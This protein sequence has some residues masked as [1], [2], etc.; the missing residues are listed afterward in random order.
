ML[1]FSHFSL[2]NLASL[3][4]ITVALAEVWRST[5]VG[6]ARRRMLAFLSGCALYVGAVVLDTGTYSL[7]SLPFFEFEYPAIFFEI[8][9]FVELS[10]HVAGVDNKRHVLATRVFAAIVVPI[11]LYF[12]YIAVSSNAAYDSAAYHLLLPLPV[13]LSSYTFLLL[14]AVLFKKT[15]VLPVFLLSL[16]KA[17]PADDFRSKATYYLFLAAGLFV[18]GALMPALNVNTS[19]PQEMTYGLYYINNLVILGLVVVGFFKYVERRACLATKIT[20][21]MTVILMSVATS[22][23]L[24]FHEEQAELALEDVALL[25][26]S[27]II[28]TPAGIGRDNSRYQAEATPASWAD[29]TALNHTTEK[30]GVALDLPFSFPFYG[31][32][33]NRLHILPSGQVVPFNG[34]IGPKP[35]YSNIQCLRDKPPIAPFCV[36][37]AGYK[38]QSSL[39]ADQAVITWTQSKGNRPADIMQL[40]IRPD[41]SIRLNY[42]DVPVMGSVVRDTSIGIHNGVKLALRTQLLSALPLVTSQPMVWFDLNLGRRAIVHEKLWPLAAYMVFTILA[43]IMFI[44]PYLVQRI[45]TPLNTLS[46]GLTKVDS[47]NLDSKL[48]LDTQDEFGDLAAGFNGMIASLELARER[49]DEQTELLETELTRRTITAASMD[50]DEIL[51]KDQTFEQKI[52]KVITQNMGNFNFQVAELA[53]DMGMSTRQLHR[54][55]VDLT[56]ETPAALIRALRLE[57]AYQLLANNAANISQAAHRSGFKDVSYF[58]KRFQQRFTISPKEL[59]AKAP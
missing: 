48:S 56:A 36:P 17:L 32:N 33:Y 51:S 39:Q 10:R 20:I 44:R 52:K 30:E 54:K 22:V 47:G 3:L 38:F 24:L 25:Q 18:F 41:G 4:L 59:K 1:Y 40:V 58:S 12:Y 9:A 19:L 29:T 16:W 5:T 23:I 31:Q 14:G 6:P 46:T 27:S 43:V 11:W 2:M 57:H 45:V 34:S 42:R 26:Q 13:L 35:V 21:G 28:I 15:R 8:L 50:G 53:E 55:V 7:G 37:G 49:A